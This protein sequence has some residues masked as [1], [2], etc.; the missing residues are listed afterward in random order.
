MCVGLIMTAAL[1]A[2][3]GGCRKGVSVSEIPGTWTMS[4]SAQR[5]FP[6]DFDVTSA[7]FVFKDDKT[8]TA[9]GLPQEIVLL[10]AA[11]KD[12]T[13]RVNATGTWWLASDRSGFSNAFQ[14]AMDF[15]TVQGPGKYQLPFSTMLFSAE[16]TDAGILIYYF[17]DDPDLGRRVEFVKQK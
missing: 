13:E 7:T 10:K 11:G 9:T 16:K 1:L 2:C 14:M 6:A 5:L 8:F 12:A 17:H 3:V 15:K 4:R